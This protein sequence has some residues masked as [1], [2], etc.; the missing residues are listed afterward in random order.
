MMMQV[1]RA[2]LCVLVSIVIL[3]GCATGTTAIAPGEPQNKNKTATSKNVTSP[4]SP[5]SDISFGWRYLDLTSA[6][7]PNSQIVGLKPQ[8]S[9]LTVIAAQTVQ[10][11]GLMNDVYAAAPLHLSTWAF[12]SQSHPAEAPV[13]Y[14]GQWSLKFGP[15]NGHRPVTVTLIHDGQA[16]FSLPPSIPGYASEVNP[17]PGDPGSFDNRILGESGPWL[18][19][20]MKGPGDPPL[21]E[22]V[23]GYRVWDRIVAIN[24]DT[25]QTFV[26]SIPPSTSSV[27]TWG[28]T[29][30]FAEQNGVV[31]IGT[32]S[33]LGVFPAKPSA[34]FKTQ[35]VQP[36]PASVEKQDEKDMLKA[37]QQ[38]VETG[39][40]SVALLWNEYI[41]RGKT[42][43]PWNSW[44]LSPLWYVHG[45]L[46]HDI[47]WAVNFPLE[48]NS[49]A[50]QQRAKLLADLETLLK[51]PLPY[52][53]V[54]YTSAP[55]LRKHFHA[56]PPAPL[57]GYSVEQGYYVKN[58]K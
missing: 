33:W 26:Y 47:A 17:P 36:E 53:Y 6:F 7:G 44:I 39:A 23:W 54:A 8:D 49:E 27:D 3:S 40:D 42:N 20:A 38:V 14:S 56:Q 48:E 31:Y 34:T 11:D 25:R 52:A 16:V 15:M 21:P 18:W 24:T 12:T 30:A 19:L 45:T 46:P 50:F 32:G 4:L 35:V 37:L 58:H 55:D 28:V 13:G 10:S 29:P 41:M 2:G 43:I 22:L 5:A 1:A 57:P 9:V 51:N